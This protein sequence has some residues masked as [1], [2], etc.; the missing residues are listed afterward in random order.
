M[1]HADVHACTLCQASSGLGQT[2]TNASAIQRS[3]VSLPYLQ[4]IPM[5]DA[6][7]MTET[8]NLRLEELSVIALQ[9]LSGCAKPTIALL[10]E[11]VKHQ[12]HVK[13]YEIL[14]KDKVGRAKMWQKVIRRQYAGICI[15]A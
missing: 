3:Y 7:Q 15:C 8:F 2:S 11:D 13:T 4:I 5:D 6:G 1:P 9:F 12:R 14:V 10:C